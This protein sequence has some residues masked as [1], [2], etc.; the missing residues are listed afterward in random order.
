[1]FVQFSSDTKAQFVRNTQTADTQG[2]LR[3]EVEQQPG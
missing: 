1:M 2:V 3:I